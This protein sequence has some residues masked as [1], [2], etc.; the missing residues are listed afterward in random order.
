MMEMKHGIFDEASISVI[1]S[2]T[3]CEIGSQGGARTCD[4]FARLLSLVCCDRFP[5]ART[6]G[7]AVCSSFGQGDDGP[8]ITITMRDVR[9]SMVNLDPDSATPAPEVMKAVVRA[10]QNN[11]GFRSGKTTSSES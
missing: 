11:A 1:A 5:S 8:A 2:D 4:D 9:G 6:S 3:V 7:W 10:N